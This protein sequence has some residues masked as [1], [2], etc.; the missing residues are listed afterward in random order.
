LRE[1]VACANAK[2][3][4]LPRQARLSLLLVKRIGVFGV[5]NIE[6]DTLFTIIIP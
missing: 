4:G 1:R 3:Q 5:D 2:Q 6:I